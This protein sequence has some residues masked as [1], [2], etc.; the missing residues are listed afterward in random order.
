MRQFAGGAADSN[1]YAHRGLGLP[2]AC[3]TMRL[4]QIKRHPHIRPTEWLFRI[5]WD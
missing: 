2:L 3:T 5:A 1:V 4:S